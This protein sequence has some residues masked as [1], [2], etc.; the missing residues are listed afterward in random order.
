MLV[1][2]GN[3]LFLLSALHKE[4]QFPLKLLPNQNR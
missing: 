1:I 4:K 2:T 3:M